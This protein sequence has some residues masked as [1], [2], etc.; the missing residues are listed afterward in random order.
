MGMLRITSQPLPSMGV[1][2]RIVE[3]STASAIRI[4]EQQKEWR[5]AY[6]TLGQRVTAQIQQQGQ[7]STADQVSLTRLVH[8][9]FCGE[10][11]S[12]LSGAIAQVNELAREEVGAV[13]KLVEQVSSGQISSEL[14][15]G[16]RAGEEF[17]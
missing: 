2:A 10:A 14:F 8:R 16:H 7:R 1:P 15:P 4:G 13:R 9:M 5:L 12:G 3:P 17:S 11:E 6:D